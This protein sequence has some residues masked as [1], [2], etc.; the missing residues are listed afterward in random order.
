MNNLTPEQIEAGA[1]GIYALDP[2]LA[3]G[4]RRFSAYPNL[5][6]FLH[7]T[8][9]TEI[10]TTQA[11]AALVAA[12]G[13]APQ[14]PTYSVAT[15]HWS[16]ACPCI[17]AEQVDPECE[18]HGRP[19]FRHGGVL[20]PST[21]SVDM[22]AKAAR[23][24]HIATCCKLDGGSEHQEPQNNDLFHAGVVLNAVPL[25]APMQVD[26]AKLAELVGW[27]PPSWD[28]RKQLASLFQDHCAIP[29]SMS[30]ASIYPALIAVAGHGYEL[31][32]EHASAALGEQLRGGQ[33]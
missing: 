1:R 2:W 28:D 30:L 15:G 11:R 10:Y 16:G 25:A 14:E 13:A 7:D 32:K 9:A 20:H 29:E 12:A 19:E 4:D 8:A 5:R 17:R 26:E 6:L 33:Q 21:P 31:A 24:L 22:V 23:V 18:W 3:G 27:E